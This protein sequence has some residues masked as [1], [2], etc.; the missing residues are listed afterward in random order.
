MCHYFRV[1]VFTMRTFEEFLEI[2]HKYPHPIYA[3]STEE[4]MAF[5]NVICKMRLEGSAH[6]TRGVQELIKMDRW[7]EEHFPKKKADPETLE[8]KFHKQMMTLYNKRHLDD[9]E[10]APHEKD[11]MDLLYYQTNHKVRRRLLEILNEF[12]VELK[13]NY[14]LS[15]LNVKNIDEWCVVTRPDKNETVYDD[16]VKEGFS[17][18]GFPP[19]CS[20]AQK[21]ADFI[22][23]LFFFKWS[24]FLSINISLV[25]VHEDL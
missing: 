2:V 20:T 24:E 9:Y 6:N 13:F 8:Q 18:F 7:L 1:D 11:L 5:L 19:W 21:K 10:R 15:P 25:D 14:I 22:N 4:G 3:L 23:W 17:G 16:L 12:G